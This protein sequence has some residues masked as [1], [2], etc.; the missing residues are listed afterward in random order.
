VLPK[1]KLIT[2]RLKHELLPE[3]F[4]TRV[5]DGNLKSNQA[6]Q[7]WSDLPAQGIEG[8]RSHRTHCALKPFGCARTTQVRNDDVVTS[9]KATCCCSAAKQG[10]YE[11]K[12]WSNCARGQTSRAA[13]DVQ[14]VTSVLAAFQHVH[15]TY[16]LIVLHGSPYRA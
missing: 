4:L 15:N 3:L 11:H 1:Q 7:I 5:V 6:S 14:K 8:S 9:T 16:V 2:S 12:P 10:C 13:Q